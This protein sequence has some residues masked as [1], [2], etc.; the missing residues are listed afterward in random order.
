V[1]RAGLK[2]K[3]TV[4]ED[5]DFAMICHLLSSKDARAESCE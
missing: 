3:V 5:N 4:L 2:G 1:T